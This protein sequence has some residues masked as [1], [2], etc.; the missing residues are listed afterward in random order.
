MDTKLGKARNAAN[1]ALQHLSS[2]FDYERLECV[3][4]DRMLA[5]VVDLPTD[6][7]GKNTRRN[8]QMVRDWMVTDGPGVV[9]LEVLGQFY[10]RLGDLNSKDFEALKQGLH[11]QQLYLELVRDP[12]STAFIKHRVK[13]VQESKFDAF[14]VFIQEW[15]SECRVSLQGCI[16][17]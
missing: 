2:I 5:K 6:S 3:Y 13:R 15:D 17:R 1:D 8:L 16:R 7:K 10:W 4:I 9:M 11:Q 12:K 14:D